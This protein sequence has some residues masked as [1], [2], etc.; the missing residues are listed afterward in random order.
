MAASS[1]AKAGASTAAAAAAPDARP[2]LLDKQFATAAKAGGSSPSPTKEAF[3]RAEQSLVDNFKSF[4]N[5][6]KYSKK[7]PEG[8][9]L[10]ERLAQ[11][12][13]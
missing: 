2:C 10:L 5:F 13:R 6:E 3:K 8:F 7:G 1:T 9:S 4:S 12:P 11:D